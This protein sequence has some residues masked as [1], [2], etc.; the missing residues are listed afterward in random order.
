VEEG[1]QEGFKGK[2]TQEPRT[3][4]GAFNYPRRP[5]WPFPKGNGIK[6]RN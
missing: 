6:L 5:P 1:T 3:F 4:Q 2:R